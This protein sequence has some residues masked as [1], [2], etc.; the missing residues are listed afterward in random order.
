MRRITSYN[1]LAIGLCLLMLFANS[2]HAEESWWQKGLNTLKGLE[3][4]QSA[5][6]ELT[7][8]ELSTA[9]KQAL[10]LGSEKVVAQLAK[11]D[12]FNSDPQVHIPL[13]AAIE[14][15]RP[16]LDKVG[17]SA[18]VAELELKLNRAAE[19]ATPKAQALF[20][21][22]IKDMSF[23]DVQAIYQGPEDSATQYF[24]DKM[25][26]SLAAEMQPIVSNSLAEV[27]AVKVY[28]QLISDYKNIPFVPDLKANL[29]EHV[30]NKGM[31]GLFYYLAKE[32]AAIRKDPLKQSTALL[33][34][35]FANQ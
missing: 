3:V 5:V 7:A 29:T 18:T 16:L 26:V 27:G 34:K 1:T 30:V 32:E 10:Q 31:D 21:Q 15:A 17:M 9:F 4:D 28:D 13:P 35:V 22:A 12:G 33:K 2:A 11:A 20:V 6:T 14:K 19:Q 23:E 25:Q 8:A 24:K